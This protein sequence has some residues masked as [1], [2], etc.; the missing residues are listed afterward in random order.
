MNILSLFF[1]ALGIIANVAIYQQKDR[2][3]LLKTKLT[4]NVFWALSYAFLNAYSGAFNCS[5][6]VLREFVFLNR[7]RKWASSKIWLVFFMVLMALVAVITWK[8]IFNIFPSTASIIAVI[9]FWIGDPKLTRILQF[10]CSIL[11]LTYNIYCGSVMGIVNEFFSITS[12][13]IALIVNRK[14]V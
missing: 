1:G 7:R 4:A 13:I 5:I 14:K 12:I 11:Y 8:S 2:D 3:K 10:P 9:I 6:C